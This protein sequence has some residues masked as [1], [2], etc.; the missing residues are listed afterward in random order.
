MAYFER[1]LT[2][3]AKNKAKMSPAFGAVTRASEIWRIEGDHPP[4]HSGPR[5]ANRGNVLRHQQ[6]TERSTKEPARNPK[7]NVA[8]ACPTGVGTPEPPEARRNQEPPTGTK[9]SGGTRK[10]R[11]RAT[12][13]RTIHQPKR[14]THWTR[15]QV[16]ALPG[17]AETTTQKRET[18]TEHRPNFN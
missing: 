11:S 1:P 16:S 15:A 12:R 10:R 14:A 8:H 7:A 18:S 4:W 13:N 5:S 3:Q 9:R 17:G 2:C 6:K